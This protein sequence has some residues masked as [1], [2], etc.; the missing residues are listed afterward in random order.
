MNMKKNATT[1]RP[2]AAIRSAILS[3]L[4]ASRQRAARMNPGPSPLAT[5]GRCGLA[6]SQISVGA[7]ASLSMLFWV[8]TVFADPSGGQVASG[9]GSISHNGHSTVINQ[10]SQNLAINWNSFSIGADESVR[11]DQPNGTAI[12]LN[13]VLGQS[14]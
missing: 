5:G 13:R 1:S 9:N 10:Q 6:G 7:C 12:A 4:E 3:A 2:K 14:P 11:F 8:P